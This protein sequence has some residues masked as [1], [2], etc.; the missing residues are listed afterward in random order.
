MAKP[1]LREILQ[2]AIIALVLFFVL[3]F[4]VQNFRINGTSMEPNLHDGQYV[5][6]NKTAYWFGHNPHRGDII[7]LH[8]P[9]APEF[10]RIKRVIGLPGETVEVRRDGSVYV[11][12]YPL[13]EPYL[14]NDTGG[15]AGTWQV[16]PDQYFVLGDNRA[17]SYDSRAWGAVPREYIVGRAWLII[18]GIGDWGTVPNY[19][20]ALE[21]PG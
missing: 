21:T 9:E 13:E 14:E 11:D 17:V 16:P 4:V 12:G 6:V 15:S 3:H 5:L 1:I 20:L 19:P 7:V 18:W 10:D 2:I 8:A